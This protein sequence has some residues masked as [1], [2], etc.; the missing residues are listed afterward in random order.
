[1]FIVGLTGGI[2]SGKSTV[3][4]LFADKAV[5]VIDTDIIARKVVAPGTSG[6][7]QIKK[8]FGN[9]VITGQDKLDRTALRKII[10]SDNKKRKQLEDILHPLIREKAQYQINNLD[11]DYCIIVIPLLIETGHP[12]KLDR[13][14]VVDCDEQIQIERTI[15]RDNYDEVQVKKILASQVDRK[16]R[17]AKADDIITNNTDLDMLTNQVNQLHLKYSRLA[18][19]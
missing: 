9:T 17:L 10:Y 7:D 14:L 15:A 8:V 13:I 1:M 3:A 5:P 18:Q 6:L 4:N 2:G 19:V 12:Y 11:N 16:T